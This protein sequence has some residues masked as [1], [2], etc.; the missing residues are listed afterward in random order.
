MITL[1]SDVLTVDPSVDLVRLCAWCVPM[2]RRVELHRAYRCSDGMCP[3]CQIRFAEQCQPCEL[4]ITYP[5][6]NAH[7]L[8]FAS[9]LLRGL[10]MIAAA[11]QPI[12]MRIVSVVLVALACATTVQAQE[13]SLVQSS[14]DPIYR[15]GQTAVLAAHVADLATTLNGW[16]RGHHETNPLIGGNHGGRLLAVKTLS[17]GAQLLLLHVL[18][19]TGH[20]KAAGFVGL[21]SSA[22]AALAAMHNARLSGGVR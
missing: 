14:S 13:R 19:K 2:A 15:L 6:G 16:S 4:E 8:T 10:W 17:T 1:K 3:D 9:R 18:A 11:A 5:S 20:A 7:T 12:T 21:G 22:P